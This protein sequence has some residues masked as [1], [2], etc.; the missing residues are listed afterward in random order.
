MNIIFDMLIYKYSRDINRSIINIHRPEM[1]RKPKTLDLEHF[2]AHARKIICYQQGI[3]E[4]KHIS[5]FMLAQA[6][7]DCRY[8]LTQPTKY[9]TRIIV[10]EDKI[11][12]FDI[13]FSTS[14]AESSSWAERMQ[15]VVH[16]AIRNKC[17][18]SHDLYMKYYPIRKE[19][20]IPPQVDWK[21]LEKKPYWDDE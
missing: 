10:L 7:K 14:I 18:V 8:H 6:I 11:W 20:I 13:Y 17:V 15:R 1:N 2:A 12:F 19:E 21:A 3:K 4:W 9:R 16:E 5:A